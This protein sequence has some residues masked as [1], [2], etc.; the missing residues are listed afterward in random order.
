[1]ELLNA[2]KF[3]RSND[4]VELNFNGCCNSLDLL[5]DPTRRGEA[6]EMG[7]CRGCHH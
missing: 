6:E 4:D 1:M 3:L 7:E 5:E 2:F